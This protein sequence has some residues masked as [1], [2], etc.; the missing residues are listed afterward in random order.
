MLAMPPARAWL[1]RN[2][3]A[4]LR[5]LLD[6]PGVR[7]VPRQVLPFDRRQEVPSVYTH[8]PLARRHSRDLPRARGRLE[9]RVLLEH[10]MHLLQAG[11]QPPHLRQRQSR[12]IHRGGA[13]VVL[14]MMWM[15]VFM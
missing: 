13:N 3:G 14:A 7:G 10:C 12:A 5:P 4:R 9:L 6:R 1:R 2:T 8:G 11:A 15:C